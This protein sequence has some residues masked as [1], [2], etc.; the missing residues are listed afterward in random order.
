[1]SDSLQTAGGQLLTDGSLWRGAGMLILVLGLMV[2]GVW[3]LKRLQRGGQPTALDLEVVGRL[4]LAPKQHLSVVRVGDEHW[5]LGVTDNSIRFIGEYHG[6]TAA[7][8]P[9]QAG[10]PSFA[11]ALDRSVKR[12]G[13][14]FARK[15]EALV[16][17][18]R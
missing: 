8:Q 2:A 12:L 6:E 5:V 18:G 4:G 16:E 10:R 14:A 11:T 3:F 15:H 1:V 13:R 17:P 9:G 7:R